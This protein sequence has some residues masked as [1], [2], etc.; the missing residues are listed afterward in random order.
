MKTIKLLSTVLAVAIVAIATAVEKPKMNLVPLS[1]DRAV[2]TIQN[3]NASLFELSIHAENGELVYYKQTTKPLNSYQK[4]YDFANLENGNY[5]MDVRVNDTR[6][7][8]D[9]EVASK[10]IFVGESKLRI[11]PYFAFAGDVLKLTYL[12]FDQ[13]SLSLNIYDE[14][15]LVYESKLGKDFN[16]AAGY[17][18]SSLREG[19]YEVVLS[20]LNN[21]FSFSL[22]K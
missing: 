2:I 5:T 6:I 3:E 16:V 19:E 4:I 20:S 7:L 12:N 10:G 21:D 18:L 9:F 14:N 22:V 17:D 11:D 1:A 8:K 15:G 13:E